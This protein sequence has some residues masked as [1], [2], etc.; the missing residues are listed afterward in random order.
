VFF[1]SYNVQISVKN[2]N[3]FIFKITFKATCFSSTE[4]SSGLSN[5][6]IQNQHLQCIWDPKCLHTHT[7]TYI[8][9]YI[10]IYTHRCKHL[11]SQTHCKC[12]FWIC[13]LERPDDG[14]VELK[15]VALNVILKIKR[16]LFLTE[17]FTLYELKNTSGWL[18]LSERNSFKI[19]GPV[20]P[21]SVFKMYR[22]FSE[23]SADV[24]QAV[25]STT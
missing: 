24:Y 21:C 3:P 9:I 23:T 2:N 11:G 22:Q 17:I 8:Y 13:S 12:W 1:S 4:P 18:T 20:A 6:Q 14:S 16:L 10:Y 5:E 7:H 15:H 19:V 25:R